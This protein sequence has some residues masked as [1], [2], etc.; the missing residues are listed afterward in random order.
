MNFLVL[1]KLPR[2]QPS[3]ISHKILAIAIVIIVV[4][5]VIIIVM[6]DIVIIVIITTVIINLLTQTHTLACTLI[7]INAHV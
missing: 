6:H 5:I 3:T 4:V 1:L 7:H 2:D